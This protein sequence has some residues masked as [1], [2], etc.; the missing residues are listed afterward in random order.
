MYPRFVV[1]RS[2]AGSASH[3][4][5]EVQQEGLASGTGVRGPMILAHSPG[6]QRNTVVKEL[7]LAPGHLGSNPS[8]VLAVCL[9]LG[10]CLGFLIGKPGDNN[11]TSLTGLPEV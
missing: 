8:S 10:V 9:T 4:Q 2:G 3:S 7:T 5:G 11:R 6:G 1:C